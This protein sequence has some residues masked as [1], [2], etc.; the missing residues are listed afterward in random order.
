M[1]VQTIY[2]SLDR[3]RSLVERYTLPDGTIPTDDHIEYDVTPIVV[4]HR[5]T[6]GHIDSK[7]ITDIQI[8]KALDLI[9]DLHPAAILLDVYGLDSFAQACLFNLY[10]L[11]VDHYI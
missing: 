4:I 6:F 7:L 3:I 11:S 2:E 9:H 8:P 10:A 5:G 1:K